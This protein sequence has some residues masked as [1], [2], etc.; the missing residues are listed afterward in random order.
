MEALKPFPDYNY[1]DFIIFTFV[2][3]IH[4][5]LIL[6]ALFLPAS[7]SFATTFA[8]TS[9]L[10]KYD[11]KIGDSICGDILGNCTLNAA[12]QE[13]NAHAGHDTIL[14]AATG[15]L[16]L[17]SGLVDLTDTAGCTIIGPGIENFE[18]DGYHAQGYI[19]YLT[20]SKHNSISGVRI[21]NVNDIAIYVYNSNNNSFTNLFIDGKR[22]AS[23]G[24]SLIEIEGNSCY[25]TIVNCRVR[26]GYIGIRFKAG[27]NY[28]TAKNCSSTYQLHSGLTI[29][30][31]NYNTVAGNYIEASDNSGTFIIFGADH[32]ILTDNTIINNRERGI[33]L[34]NLGADGGLVS[35]NH[36]FN[37]TVSGNLQ[38]NIY[39]D[40]LAARDNQISGISGYLPSATPLSGRRN[41]KDK[42]R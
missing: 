23:E 5:R 26:C 16:T 3:T 27:S 13:A 34:S 33:I 2:R 4:L 6:F 35:N 37:N 24:G 9:L 18:I 28:N 40:E 20:H 38:G 8:V 12:I 7:H 42:Q 15:T 31:S 30:D 29:Y 21:S 10:S 25:N 1:S 36:I 32:N 41:K 11:A 22:A 19:F 39:E 14:I 17:Y